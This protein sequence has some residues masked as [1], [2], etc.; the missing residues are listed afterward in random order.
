MPQFFI[1]ANFS[2]GTV[3]ELQPESKIIRTACIFSKRL[4]SAK[5]SNWY[6]LTVPKNRRR[7]I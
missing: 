1:T 4:C 3:P 5:L 7:S 6:K 2:N